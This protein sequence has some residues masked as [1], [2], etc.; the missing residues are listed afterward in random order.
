LQ[1]E[2]RTNKSIISSAVLIIFFISSILIFEKVTK[3]NL[4]Y[5]GIVPRDITGLLGIIISPL[6]HSGWQHLIGNMSSL[7]ILLIVLFFLYT[8]SSIA[9]LTLIWLV[10]GALVWLF[11]RENTYH[12]GA[13]GVIFG[14]LSFLFF[15]GIFK[16]DRQ[17]MMIS[18]LVLIL[19]GGLFNG[20]MP[21]EGISWESHLYGSL[22]GLVIAFVFKNVR[23]GYEE[24]R[25]V[26]LAEN[27]SK[28]LPNDIF[29]YTKTERYQIYLAKLEEE[30]KRLQEENEND[31]N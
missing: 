19:N 30:Q 11:A 25:I 22:A 18:L 2:Y 24:S 28:Y 7:L 29:Q 17:S 5:Y 10:T 14:L 12:I 26:E 1:E 4:S 15:S 31:L 21:E 9:V 23:Q 16:G 6:L 3:I 20:F 13:S 27:K 8:R